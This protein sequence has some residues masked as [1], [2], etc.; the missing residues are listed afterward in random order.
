MVAVTFDLAL[1]TGITRMCF[2]FSG[3]ESEDS[4]CLVL[5][6]IHAETRDGCRVQLCLAG[7]AFRD[8]IGLMAIMDAKG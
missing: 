4:V 5:A 6:N 8:I 7:L 1:S 3:F 2:A